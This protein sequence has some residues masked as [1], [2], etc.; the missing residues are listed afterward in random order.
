[1]LERAREAY[2]RG[3]WQAAID[4]LRSVDDLEGLGADDLRR[5]AHA[6]QCAGRP[7]EALPV[8]ERAVAAYTARGDQQG[9]AW[10]AILVAS[11]RLEWG[12]WTLANGWLQRAARLLE[13]SPACRE[14]GY[15]EML[16]ALRDVCQP[17]RSGA[18]ARAAS[19][20][21]RARLR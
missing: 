9:A 19:A 2:D 18:H 6:A 13:G 4:L 1:M 11:L 16:R 21:D 17:P 14:H 20:R 7:S 3:E 15:V 5:W 8:L 12:E 10:A